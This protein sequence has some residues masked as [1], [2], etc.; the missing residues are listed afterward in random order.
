M[1]APARAQGGGEVTGADGFA[2]FDLG[3]PGDVPAAG[4]H[5]R[6]VRA[7]DHVRVVLFGFAA[8]EELSEHTASRPA[9]IHVLSGVFEM[10]LGGERVAAPAGTLVHMAAGR[11]HA[12]RATEPSR[13]LLTLIQ[14]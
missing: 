4:I 2:V 9:M 7:D 3:G 13:M 10:T 8:G 14:D 5:S 6:T 1:R 11:R 12:L